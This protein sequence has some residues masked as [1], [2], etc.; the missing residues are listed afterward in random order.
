VKTT[1]G[2]PVIA[3]FRELKLAT[4]SSSMTQEHTVRRGA[5]VICHARAHVGHLTLGHSMGFN[6]NG[7]LR[8][9]EVL[10]RKTYYH[11]EKEDSVLRHVD[12]IRKRETFQTLF[13]N[14]IIP[15]DL[16]TAG[17]VEVHGDESAE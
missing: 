8:A 17:D 6:Y 10:L 14:T 9:P 15:S 5:A 16:A 12:L 3:F 11:R 1:T 2:L 4:S 13:G 7:A